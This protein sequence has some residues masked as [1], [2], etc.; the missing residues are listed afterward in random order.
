MYQIY[1]EHM[2]DIPQ[3]IAGLLCSAIVS[4]TLLFRSPTCTPADRAAAERLAVI[5]GIDDLQKYAA[6]MFHAGSSLGN[7]SADEIFYQDFK[8]F[9]LEKVTF[10]V[11]QISSMD[12][13]ELSSIKDKLL[14]F[15]ENEC[16]RND[17][18]MVFFMLTNIIEE[19]TEL[20]FC[21]NKAEEL[22]KD[23]FSADTGENSCLLSGVI[24]RK[25]QLIPAFMTALQDWD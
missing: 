10:G 24:S 18:Q 23:A 9:M 1:Q 7:K 8:K 4:D 2:L 16:S 13:A 19:K 5:A 21:G 12:A 3:K 17:I 11:G 14:P 15:M 22:V 6:A 20:L 25:K